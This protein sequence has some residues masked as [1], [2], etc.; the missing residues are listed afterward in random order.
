VSTRSAINPEYEA[1]GIHPDTMTCVAI[2]SEREAKEYVFS[3][4]CNGIAATVSIDPHNKKLR[5]VAVVGGLAYNPGAYFAS[6]TGGRPRICTNDEQGQHPL[7]Q[8][9]NV[10]I[11]PGRD[12][13]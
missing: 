7:E 1:L 12:E 2:L 10:A 11:M 4:A 13:R 9:E 6:I 3:L 5:H 8:N